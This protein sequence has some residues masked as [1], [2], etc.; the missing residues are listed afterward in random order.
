LY[1]VSIASLQTQSP[2]VHGFMVGPTPNPE[3][4]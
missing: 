1:S 2:L 4:L 3:D